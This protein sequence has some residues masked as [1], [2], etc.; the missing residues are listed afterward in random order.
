[1][2]WDPGFLFPAVAPT[3]GA[4]DRGLPSSAA[5]G[6]GAA[7]TR[8]KQAVGL[9]SMVV[10]LEW[11]PHSGFSGGGGLARQPEASWRQAI[12][13]LQEAQA[14]PAALHTEAG[15]VTLHGC[16][17]WALCKG[18]EAIRAVAL[19]TPGIFL[20]LES[21]PLLKSWLKP[22]A[23]RPPLPTPRDEA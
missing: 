10:L 21:E 4:G 11:G 15:R 17:G 19:P 6:E 9:L 23:T 8:D 7:V 5:D 16:A 18:L 13:S 3:G 1:M 14:P 20:N 22:G 12:P 2:T